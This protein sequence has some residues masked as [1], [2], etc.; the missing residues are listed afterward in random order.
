MICSVKALV[1]PTMA[2]V[3]EYIAIS[4]PDEWFIAL[5][6]SFNKPHE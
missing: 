1:F 5:F 6:I 3:N 4:M 2:S